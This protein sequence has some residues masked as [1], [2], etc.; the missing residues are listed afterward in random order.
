[1]I[2]IISPLVV[3]EQKLYDITVLFLEDIK[4]GMSLDDE[5]IIVDNG[6]T[7]GREYY[8][9]ESDIYIHTPKPIGYGGAL[10]LG[11][12]VAKGNF[13]LIPNNDMRIGHDWSKKMLE[14]FENN[15]KVGIVSCHGPHMIPST[16][17]AFNGIFWM[18]RKE[19]VDDIGYFDIFQPRQP[20]DADFCLRAVAAGWDITTAEFFYDH[21]NRKSTHNQ[22]NF[23]I[24]I[25][26]SIQWKYGTFYDKWGIKEQNW[27][28]KGLKLHELKK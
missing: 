23:D 4:A 12:K 6:S 19:V 24:A 3:L 27:Y 7:I 13:F 14:V 15:P 8:M 9:N 2:S 25:K 20:D 28:K 22:Q 16:G 18:I 17:S 26:D 5:L 21:P 10:N 11:M 1:M